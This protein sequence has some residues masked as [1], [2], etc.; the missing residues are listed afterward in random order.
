MGYVPYLIRLEPLMNLPVWVYVSPCSILYRYI[1]TWT[2]F[3]FAVPPQKLNIFDDRGNE[4]R[5]NHIGPYKENATVTITC[6]ASGGLTI[7]LNFGMNFKKCCPI[8]AGIIGNMFL[9]LELVCG[10]DSLWIDFAPQV[11]LAGT[12]SVC[13]P[14][15]EAEAV[16]WRNVA[17]V[18]IR[19]LLRF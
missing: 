13:C 19:R 6:A 10:S 12:S 1:L 17:K 11:Q 7:N 18:V 15:G 9:P 16:A 8:R 2:Y 3:Y 5:N 14:E 4:L